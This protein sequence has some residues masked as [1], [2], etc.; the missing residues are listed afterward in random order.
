MTLDHLKLGIYEKALSSQIDWSKRLN[1]AKRC[2]FQFVEISID[3][4]DNRLDRLNWD[5]SERQNFT[6]TVRSSGLT[7][8]SMC[9]SAH[10]RYPLGSRDAEV[11][12]KARKIME[13][14]IHFCVETGIRTIQLAGYD[15]YYEKGD[16]ETEKWFLDGL[17]TAVDLASSENVMLAM[18]IMDHPLMRSIVRYLLYEKQLPSPWFALY[19]DLG[20]LSAWGND[21]CAELRLGIN[22]IVAIHL[23]DTLAVSPDFPGKFKGVP[24]GEGCVNFSEAFSTLLKLKYT[25]PFLIEMWTENTENPEQEIIQARNWILSAMIKSGYLDT[26]VGAIGIS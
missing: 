10:R 1:I 11:R 20:N 14:A 25:G 6:S 17:H 2:G 16:E 5:S 7:V 12:S 24:F 21:V 8:P 3:E 19:P 26:P 9:L 18:E 4:T 15:V 13:D 23:K 22:R